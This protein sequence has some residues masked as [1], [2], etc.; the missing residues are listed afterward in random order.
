MGY[1]AATGRG[2][3]R[4]DATHARDLAPCTDGLPAPQNS[5]SRS[6][7]MGRLF[8]LARRAWHGAAQRGK[9]A[10]GGVAGSETRGGVRWPPP[11]KMDRPRQRYFHWCANYGSNQSRVA[12]VPI[13]GLEIDSCGPLAAA[14]SRIKGVGSYPALQQGRV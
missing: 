6:T 12:A 1:P 11:E 14:N 8:V 3:S 5:S 2:T 7:G 13:R 4:T 9:G 10:K